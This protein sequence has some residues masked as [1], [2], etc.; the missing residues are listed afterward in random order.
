MVK[1]RKIVG[2]KNEAPERERERERK[3]EREREREIRKNTML[4]ERVEKL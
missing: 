3:I 4:W 2:G 1:S